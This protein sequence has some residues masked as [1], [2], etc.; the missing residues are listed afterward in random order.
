M[1]K[2]WRK[3]RHRGRKKRNGTEKMMMQAGVKSSTGLGA[4]VCVCVCSWCRCTCGVMGFWGHFAGPHVF[5]VWI[6]IR[7]RLEPEQEIGSGAR[8]GLCV[9]HKKEK[10]C[11]VCVKI[12]WHQ[13]QTVPEESNNKSILQ[14]HSA[15]W[16]TQFS[17][18]Q[19][20]LL[21][22]IDCFTGCSSTASFS[23]Q[24]LV[25]TWIKPGSCR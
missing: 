10:N 3:H 25:N 11:F 15:G 19:K 23:I 12:F 17:H 20:N 4:R 6:R 5:G 18:T 13:I 2:V 14:S 21:C 1:R 8:S 7:V 22:F 24:T 9:T 16:W